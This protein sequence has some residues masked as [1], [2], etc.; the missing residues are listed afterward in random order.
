MNAEEFAQY[1][2]PSRLEAK[3]AKQKQ[4]QRNAK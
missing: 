3:Q 4:K 1:M 2:M